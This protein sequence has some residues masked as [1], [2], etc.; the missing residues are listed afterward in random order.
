MSAI[1]TRLLRE[2]VAQA[3][4]KAQSDAAF[5]RILARRQQASPVFSEEILP[6]RDDIRAESDGVQGIPER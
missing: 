6:M 4:R 2:A 1:V 3:R 5:M